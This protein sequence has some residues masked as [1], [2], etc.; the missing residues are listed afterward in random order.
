M[1]FDNSGGDIS[2]FCVISSSE[3]ILAIV[4]YGCP[5]PCKLNVFTYEDIVNDHIELSEKGHHV[6]VS[7]AEA[8][9]LLVAWEVEQ[10]LVINTLSFHLRERLAG[11]VIALCNDSYTERVA[12]LAAGADEAITVPVQLP[13]LQAMVLAYRRLAKAAQGSQVEAPG[14]IA[15]PL[16]PQESPA[17][18]RT[19]GSLRIDDQSHRFFIEEKEVILTPREYALINYLIANAEKA[20][21]RDQILGDVWGISFETGT[22]MVDVYMYFLRRKLEAHGLKGMIETIRGFG[23]RLSLKTQQDAP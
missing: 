13:L 20:C 2:N 1:N 19:F 6:L 4:R 10:A 23:Y 14:A 22:N 9:A 17:R 7:A 5:P 11:P 8:D 3:L 21:S 18:E 16:T 15:A 12:A